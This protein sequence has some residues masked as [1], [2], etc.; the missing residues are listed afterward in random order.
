VPWTSPLLVFHKIIGSSLS[1]VFLKVQGWPCSYV[2]CCHF[3]RKLPIYLNNKATF[4]PIFWRPDYEIAERKPPF[5]FPSSANQCSDS[6]FFVIL[7]GFQTIFI[8][9]LINF[10]NWFFRKGPQLAKNGH[11]KGKIFLFASNLGSIGTPLSYPC[12]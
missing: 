6:I 4:P 7:Y 2:K 10:T 11:Q 1:L 12:I 8:V 5:V 9:F 3:N